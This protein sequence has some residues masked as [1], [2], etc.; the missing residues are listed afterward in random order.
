MI[1][2]VALVLPDL[3]KL[4]IHN[5]RQRGQGNP[6]ILT[7][8]VTVKRKST[9]PM[10][11]CLDVSSPQFLVTNCAFANWKQVRS[12]RVALMMLAMLMFLG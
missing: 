6:L 8:T 12:L 7:T 5:M 3:C 4:Q 11:R 1:H 10:I 9:S 2:T